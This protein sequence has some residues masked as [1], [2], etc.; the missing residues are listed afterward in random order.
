MQINMADLRITT[1]VTI[2]NAISDEIDE[3]WDNN[4]KARWKSMSKTFD[5]ICAHVCDRTDKDFVGDNI[6]P[7]VSAGARWEK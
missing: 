7:P 2:A 6:T 4:R 1:V 3:L 5:K